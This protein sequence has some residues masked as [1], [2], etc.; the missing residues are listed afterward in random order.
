MQAFHHR[1]L[2]L[3]ELAVRKYVDAIC[4]CTWALTSS[5]FAASTFGLMAW[6]GQPL[7]P[8]TVIVC[9]SL[10]GII[11]HPLNSLPWVLNGVIE[12]W[13]SADR[14]AKFL[15]SQNDEGRTSGSSG[16][17]P[18]RRRIYTHLHNAVLP[19]PR[20]GASEEG[21]SE[22]IG[23]SRDKKSPGGAD[24]F[25]SVTGP[26]GGDG[27]K[28]L[29]EAKHASVDTAVQMRSAS[30][31]WRTVSAEHSAE[32]HS[33]DCTL[34][35]LS[36]SVPVGSCCVLTGPSGSGK[37][38]LLSAILGD[39]A[40]V[41]GAFDVCG[42]VALAPQ[43]PWLIADT[44]QANIVMGRTMNEHRYEAVRCICLLKALL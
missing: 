22:A 37:S 3:R 42:S 24:S 14:L 7:S 27:G 21:S 4:V 15:S 34:A 30:F 8:A 40:Y 1:N 19:R 28:G 29:K 16:M 20:S 38:S 2:E 13:V 44:I 36:F 12:A 26:V 23:A 43:Q 41:S 11:I 5:I 9:L 25:A 31:S 35:N 17:P 39:M 18:P 10:F 33:Q 32:R 6:H